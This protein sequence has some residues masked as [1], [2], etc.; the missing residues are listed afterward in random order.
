MQRPAELMPW[1]CIC[2]LHFIFHLGKLFMSTYSLWEQTVCF[3]NYGN[4]KWMHVTAFICFVF[5]GEKP[6]K[7]WKMRVSVCQW[8]SKSKKKKRLNIW[9]EVKWFTVRWLHI[10]G[11]WGLQ[12]WFRAVN[13]NVVTAVIPCPHS[14][15]AL[16][17]LV[18]SLFQLFLLMM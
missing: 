1:K 2:V 9:N 11:M 17:K 12:H 18:L 10:R 15:Q 14:T 7:T 4:V 5:S 13:Y 8:N 3:Y 6:E 16:S